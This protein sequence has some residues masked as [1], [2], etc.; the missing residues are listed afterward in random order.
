MS[1]QFYQFR[2]LLSTKYFVIAGYLYKLTSL[3]TNSG[4]LNPSD[5][6][7]HHAD[8]GKRINVLGAIT[9]PLTSTIIQVWWYNLVCWKHCLALTLVLQSFL[10]WSLWTQFLWSPCLKVL[11]V[12]D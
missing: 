12:V 10:K 2:S 11:N 7:S 3:V 9:K 5:N 1:V 4:I 6:S 8:P